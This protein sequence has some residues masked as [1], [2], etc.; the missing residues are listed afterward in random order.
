MPK[1]WEESNLGHQSYQSI[2]QHF[3]N[4]FLNFAQAAHIMY[5]N[6]YLNYDALI[7]AEKCG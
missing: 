4:G 5:C 7:I 3:E 6:E 2:K 1:T